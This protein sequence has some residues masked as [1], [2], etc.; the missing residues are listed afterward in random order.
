MTEV[1][2]LRRRLA[3]LEQENAEL[4]A[5]EKPAARHGRGR[6][7]FAVALIAIGLMLA[8][9]AALGTWARMQLVDTDQ[10]VATF[11]PLAEDPD[12]Q[13]YVADEVT[14]AINAQVDTDELIGNVFDGVRDL[15]LPPRADAALGLLE[16][17]AAQGVQS[18]ISDAVGQVVA[19]PAFADVWESALR[20]THER[21][22][23]IIQGDPAA[24]LQLAE[25]GTLS[26]QLDVVVEKVKEELADRDIG[27]A[28]MIPEIDREI[29][30]LQADALVLV[31]TIYTVAV[32]AGFWLPWVVL[33]LLIAG[34]SIARRPLRA[35]T[36]TSGL[37]A[38]AFALL[39]TGIGIGRVFFIGAVS[40]SI[41]P[42][43]TASALF[44]QL[45]LLLQSTAVALA[46]L[47]VFV[48]IGS[49]LAGSTRPARALR[50][51][52]SNGTSA[53]RAAGDRHGLSTGRF[54]ELVER[55]RSVIL[56]AVAA[57]GV[58]LLFA[59]RP[60][61]MGGVIGVV[62]GVAVVFAV[63]ELVRRPVTPADSGAEDTR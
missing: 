59:N 41:M 49:W 16:A 54:G 53:L 50:T 27:I 17:P 20:V 18:L 21:A 19:S 43:A 25:D 26:L 10:F 39:A 5:P 1:D 57:I 6:T 45:T 9:V 14:V 2:E 61:T 56:I 47:G 12:V 58:L 63:V 44:A 37:F 38:V 4:R 46:V 7:V 51:A 8:P 42:A 22:I 55:G 62:V 30:I 34:V 33:A 35:L 32:A 31:R 48:A 23:A 52:T 13:A 40:P 60:P 24:A 15:G 28:E 36:W 3:A 29:P 11:A